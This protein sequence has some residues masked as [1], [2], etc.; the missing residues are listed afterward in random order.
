MLGSSDP[1]ALG[2]FYSR[3]LGE[4]SFHDGDWYS[5]TTGAQL[6]IGAHSEVKGNNDAPQR[7]MLTVEVRDVAA[8]F[9]ELTRHGA[10]VVAEPY[11]PD[12]DHGFWLA[13]VADPDG[14]YVQLATPWRGD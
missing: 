14:N 5:W 10:T 9:E 1:T 11:R 13:T 7:I 3:V 8:A 6:M 2:A 4:P 12:A